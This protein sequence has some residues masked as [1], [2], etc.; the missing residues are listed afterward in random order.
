MPR[1]RVFRP[2]RSVGLVSNHVPLVVRYIHR[3]QEHLIITCVGRSFHTYSSRH[4]KL[5]SVSERHDGEIAVLAADRNY[6]YTAVAGQVR[7][8]QRGTQLVHS[9]LPHEQPVT[10]VLS[11]GAHLITVDNASLLRVTDIQS[12]Q[13]Y[14][15]QQF[16][17]ETF[18]ISAVLHPSTY[19]NKILLGSRQGTLRLWNVARGALVHEF[20]GW[21]SA[22][23]VLEQAPALDTVA[24]GLE[25]GS[26]HVHNLQYD[27]SLMSFSQEWGA[28]TALAFRSDGPA[29]MVS[30]SADGH[31]ALWDLEERRLAG[32]MW[33]AHTSAVSGLCMLPALPL[34]ITSSSD[35]TLKVWTLDMPDGSGRLLR[36][37]EGHAAIPTTVRFY[38]QHDHIVS[39]ARDSCLRVFSSENDSYSVS[40]G[41]ASFNRNLSK[42]RRL[43]AEDPLTMPAIIALASECAREKEWDNIVTLHAGLSVATTWSYQRSC[44]GEHRLC[45]DRFKRHKHHTDREH[46]TCC[47][48]TACGN[49]VLLGYSSG[50]VDRYNM[51]S[52][53]LRG[54]LTPDGAPTA[55]T[56]P[57]RGVATSALVRH[58]LT[59]GADC[60]LNFWRLSGGQRVGQLQLSAPASR[61]V[62]HRATGLAAVALDDFTVLVVDARARS[63][64]RTFVSCA[65]AVTDLCVSGDGR[66]LLASSA[67]CCM[68]V[69]S[70][71]DAA[72]IDVL[73]TDSV[74]TSLSL[75]PGGRLLA[76]THADR[77]GVCLWTNRTLFDP[78]N[79]P[80]ID[81]TFEPS[82]VDA[83]D[84]VPENNLPGSLEKYEEDEQEVCDMEVELLGSEQIADDLITLALLPESRWAHVLTLDLILQRSK[85]QHTIQP[86]TPA[87][88][89]LPTVAGVRSRFVLPSTGQESSS[90]GADISRIQHTDM[91]LSP[92]ETWDLVMAT[93]TT[94]EDQEPARSEHEN[95]LLQHLLS[96][97]PVQLD[98]AVRQLRPAEN[99]WQ[100]AELFLTFIERQLH[101]RRHFEFIE[102]CL[103]LFLKVTSTALVEHSELLPAL[104]R[105][106]R[107]QQYVWHDVDARINSALCLTGF[108]KSSTVG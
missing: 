102:A 40:F 66:W 81:D 87:P 74:V 24:I 49:F 48:L 16:D 78:V 97:K 94:D 51:Q 68:R 33:H 32:Q 30:A 35:N 108:L 37:R 88:F 39:A 21:Q 80:P 96:L 15:E 61:L 8:W 18:L 56:G 73:R 75:G 92:G 72:L 65:A 70:L 57:V 25:N 89:F 2:Y 106:R 99:S 29:V 71:A 36:K 28:V 83:P 23:T 98:A 9:Y 41:R 5:L 84:S 42:K 50:H 67:D 105:V 13:V 79:L 104:D 26:V 82:V 59:A 3:R 85:P 12:E 100:A 44:L 34:M 20:A 62:L 60:W 1:S 38:G 52:G 43:G 14:T 4:L 17:A 77:L 76:T 11:F 55:H 10:C 95:L 93:A 19:V 64:A 63:V 90:A 31:L 86:S 58:V 103:A 22:V 46:A 45:H 27:R 54:S 91:V 107:T 47:D 101:R 6:V 69:W 7:A 53:E